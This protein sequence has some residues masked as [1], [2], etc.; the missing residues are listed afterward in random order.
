MKN[1]GIA[2]GVVTLLGL[3]GVASAAQPTSANTPATGL[4][5]GLDAGWIGYH[6]DVDGYSVDMSAVTYS[7]FVGYQFNRYIGI[8]GS[9]IGTGNAS[10]SI[11]GIDLEYKTHAVQGAVIGT[12]PLSPVGG[13]YARVGLIR[14]HATASS[15]YLGV[16]ES[17]DGTDALYGLGA[18]LT[19]GQLSGRLEATSAEINGTR[20]YRVTL[21]AYWSF[22]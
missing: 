17:D 11:Q 15:S 12:L 7:P 20:I 16:S 8:E 21:G 13:L 22:R 3:A 5:A 18:Y 2:A 14:W 4:Y 6:D 19:N 10:T 9:Y 1:R